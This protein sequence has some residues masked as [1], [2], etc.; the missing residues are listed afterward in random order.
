MYYSLDPVNA[1]LVY[2]KGTKKKR[3]RTAKVI[4]CQISDLDPQ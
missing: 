1:E 2:R 4:Q 3:K